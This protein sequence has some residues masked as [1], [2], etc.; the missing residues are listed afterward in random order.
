MPRLKL[1][2]CPFCGARVKDEYA[3]VNQ[4]RADRWVVSHYCEAPGMAPHEVGVSVAV[5]GAT[6][7][8]AVRRWN[9]RAKKGGQAARVD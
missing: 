2:P 9:C 3:T 8:E 1:A 4:F 6:K 5:Y 7:Q